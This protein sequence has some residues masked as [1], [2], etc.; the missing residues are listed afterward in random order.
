VLWKFELLPR[1]ARRSE[2]VQKKV[3]KRSRPSRAM[4]YGSLRPVRSAWS[5]QGCQRPVR[6]CTLLSFGSFPGAEAAAAVRST[7]VL[8]LPK[9]SADLFPLSRHTWPQVSFR[10]ACVGKRMLGERQRFLVSQP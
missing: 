8:H 6:R 5:S 7:Q 10:D 1:R 4:I 9:V 2:G 3:T